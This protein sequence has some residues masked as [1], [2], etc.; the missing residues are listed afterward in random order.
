M[1]AT[2]VSNTPKASND[3]TQK[4]S[5]VFNA[6]DT[7]FTF[8]YFN[9]HTH[10][11]T[12]RALLA[13]A[14]ANWKQHLPTD[15]FSADRAE[16]QQTIYGTL[17]L[18]YEHHGETTTLEVAEALNIELYLAEKFNLLG[19]NVAEAVQIRGAYSNTRALMHRQEDAYFTRKAHQADERQRFID[20]F[21]KQWIHTHEAVLA[22]N[23][24]NGHYVG[25]RTSLAD[26]KTAVAI[27]QLLNELYEFEDGSYA[28]LI[29]P[30]ATPNLWKVR[31]NVLSKDSYRQWRE[32]KTF[33]EYKAVTQGF[34]DKE[35]HEL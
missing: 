23:G 29:N 7:S 26:I 12:P 22:K 25:T 27:E 24:S 32:S 28:D 1:A 33:Q 19:D 8:Y 3:T 18:L 17:P 5:E 21:L 10:G 13:Y 15:W 16:K 35:R 9:L 2:T 30:T 20:T 34:F 11:A 4:L 14:D 31:E 6:K